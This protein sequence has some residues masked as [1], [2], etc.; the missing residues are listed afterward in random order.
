MREAGGAQSHRPISPAAMQSESQDKAHL[1]NFSRGRIRIC[2]Y[3][4]RPCLTIKTINIKRRP[5]DAIQWWS[6]RLV[7]ARPWVPSLVY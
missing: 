1:P 4:K 3:H 2:F 5:E 6:V 7:W